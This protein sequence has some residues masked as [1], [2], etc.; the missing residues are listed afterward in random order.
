MIKF[1]NTDVYGFESAIRG[2]RNPKNSWHLMDS[3]SHIC[4][5]DACEHKLDNEECKKHVKIC[6]DNICFKMGDNDKM[7]CNTLS[8]AGPVHGKFM[9]MINVT[10][11]ITCNHVWWAEFDT[12]KVATVRNSC[13]KMHKIHAKEFVKDD[14]SHEGID[15]CG[16]RTTEVFEVVLVELER[17]RKL[18]NKTQDKKYWRA[19]IELLPIGYNIKAT[20]QL[21]YEVLCG[22]YKYRK[23]HKM[24]E[25]IDFC[26]WIET[27]PYSELITC[28]VGDVNAE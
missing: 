9:R 18:F 2:M 11:D 22:M 20:V 14:F 8:S 16:G 12:Y 13:S 27:L 21:N 15:E 1:E 23:N 26:K 3:H 24:F 25:W 5:C 17:L 28:R 19:I 10:V 7:L 4:W 6:G